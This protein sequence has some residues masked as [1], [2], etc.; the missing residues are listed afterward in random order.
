MTDLIESLR[1]A[2]NAIVVADSGMGWGV[3]NRHDRGNRLAE[4][5]TR[6]VA[7][8]EADRLNREA[9]AAVLNE[10]LL[11]D[12]AVSRF[13]MGLRVEQDALAN[14]LTDDEIRAA[15]TAAMGGNDA[16]K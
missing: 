16:D 4:F 15:L 13:R 7:Q 3:Y 10:A 14:G 1:K 6:S 2:A 9:V 11:S 12:E 5:G 8:A